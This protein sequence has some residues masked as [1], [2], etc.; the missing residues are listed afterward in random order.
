MNKLN[1]HKDVS[2]IRK[3][4]NLYTTS[5]SLDYDKFYNDI[6]YVSPGIH[7]S[8]YYQE[9]LDVLSNRDLWLDIGC[10]SGNVLKK[11]YADKDIDLYGLEV[12]DKSISNAINN[13][14]KCLKG[15]ITNIFPYSDNTFDLVTATDVLE[16]IQIGDV[17]LTVSEMYRVCKVQGHCLIAPYPNP[18][19]TGE[20]HLTCKPTEWW[21]N[22]FTAAGFSLVKHLPRYGIVFRK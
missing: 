21:E 1:P 15:S 10:G 22:Q 20:L 17:K 16:H 7:L 19:Q 13:G 8:H 11:A 18:D 14:I 5:G 3:S 9:C 4:K 12:V 2:Y 6:N